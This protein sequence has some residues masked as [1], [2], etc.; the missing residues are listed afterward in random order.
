MICTLE[1]ARLLFEKKIIFK[2]QTCFKYEWDWNED[3]TFFCKELGYTI[4]EKEFTEELC[5]PTYDEII[6][7][8]RNEYGYHIQ[9]ELDCTAE[10]KYVYAIYKLGNDVE[11]SINALYPRLYSDLYYKYEEAER[12]AILETLKF[13]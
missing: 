9:I 11:D 3:D 4:S 12:D 5:F 10:P 1:I 8:F 7:K 6:R 2:Y 13:I